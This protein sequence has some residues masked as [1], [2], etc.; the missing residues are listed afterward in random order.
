M[1]GSYSVGTL[2]TKQSLAT[3]VV[4][5]FWDFKVL[6]VHD[7]FILNQ[8]DLRHLLTNTIYR[9]H[10]SAAFSIPSETHR[11]SGAK[12]ST[13]KSKGHPMESLKLHTCCGA[14]RRRLFGYRLGFT[15]LLFRKEDISTSLRM[16][17]TNGRR[18]TVSQERL[19]GAG[20]GGGGE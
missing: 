17:R 9:K 12:E 18:Q 19:P 3:N 8:L 10:Q 14:F 1:K 15:R 13:P 5:C 2:S 20:G 6:Q 7:K 4:F 16:T 11:K